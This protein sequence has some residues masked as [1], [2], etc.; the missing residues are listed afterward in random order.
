MSDHAIKIMTKEK[1][2]EMH[3]LMRQKI[4]WCRDMKMTPE[5]I[6]VFFAKA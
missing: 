4:Q 2:R 5:Q 3:E 1:K 6:D